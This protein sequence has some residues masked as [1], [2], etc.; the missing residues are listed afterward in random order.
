MSKSF[1]LIIDPNNNYENLI[2]ESKRCFRINFKYVTPYY[3]NGIQYDM[4]FM[5]DITPNK[6]HFLLPENIKEDKYNSIIS[7]TKKFMKKSFKDQ[8]V[9]IKLYNNKNE[10]LFN[11]VEGVTTLTI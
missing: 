6:F 3:A 8:I 2:Q 5:L 7:S 9:G 10:N 4:E 11:D 1:A